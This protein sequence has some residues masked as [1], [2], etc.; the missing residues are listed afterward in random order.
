MKRLAAPTLSNNVIG[1]V[2]ILENSIRRVLAHVAGVP[3]STEILSAPLTP[4]HRKGLGDCRS[5]IR[6]ILISLSV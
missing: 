5:A 2:T 3:S 6:P 4:N 1:S